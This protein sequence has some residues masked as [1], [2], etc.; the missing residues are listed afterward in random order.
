MYTIIIQHD[1]HVQ[2]VHVHTVQHFTYN[3]HVYIRTCPTSLSALHK[4]G[5]ILVPTPVGITT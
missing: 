4:V 1:V 3:T 5:S 2:H